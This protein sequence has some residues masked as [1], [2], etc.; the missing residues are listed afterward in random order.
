MAMQDVWEMR[1]P[2]IRKSVASDSRQCLCK[3]NTPLF[4]KKNVSCKLFLDN[5]PI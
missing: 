4:V 1:A 5:V 2:V 3:A